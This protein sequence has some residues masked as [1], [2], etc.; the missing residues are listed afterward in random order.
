LHKSEVL[1]GGVWLGFRT[2]SITPP[3]P[4]FQKVNFS[5]LWR[6]ASHQRSAISGRAHRLNPTHERYASAH[7][8]DNFIHAIHFL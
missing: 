5:R 4:I 7:R 2:R 8:L 6:S 1:K 3:G